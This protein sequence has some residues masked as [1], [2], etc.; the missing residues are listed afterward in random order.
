[1]LDYT[2]AEHHQPDSHPKEPPPYKVEVHLPALFKI[3]PTRKNMPTM[4]TSPITTPPAD[5]R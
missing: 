3:A 5:T 2:Y 1:M 4:R